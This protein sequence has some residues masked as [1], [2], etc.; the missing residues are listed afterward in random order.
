MIPERGKGELG[1]GEGDGYCNKLQLKVPGEDER[2]CFVV[3]RKRLRMRRSKMRR[4][5][6]SAMK[7]LPKCFSR[8]RTERSD[9]ADAVAMAKRVGGGAW[10]L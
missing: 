9:P 4:L 7:A 5:S 8:G 2:W 3:G 1:K 10:R 6:R